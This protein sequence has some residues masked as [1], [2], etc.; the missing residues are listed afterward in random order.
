[1]SLATREQKAVV[2]D[3][4]CDGCFCNFLSDKKL[5][6][7]DLKKNISGRLMLRMTDSD[8]KYQLLYSVLDSFLHFLAPAE[9]SREKLLYIFNILLFFEDSKE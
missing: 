4:V 5:R 9:H 1:M 2:T 7:K 6:E 3:F 8:Y